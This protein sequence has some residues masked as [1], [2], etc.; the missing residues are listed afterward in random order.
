MSTSKKFLTI[1][2]WVAILPFL[3]FPYIIKNILFVLTG[4]TIIY[5]AYGL[6]IQSKLS[7]NESTGFDNFSEN[8][9]FTKI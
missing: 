3:G 2:I 7:K 5:I 8:K 4:L 9:D 6:Y 1:G